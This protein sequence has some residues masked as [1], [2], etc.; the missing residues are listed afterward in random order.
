MEKNDLLEKLRIL[1]LHDEES[2]E[3]VVNSLTE[4]ER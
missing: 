4:E 2:L 1:N 3:E